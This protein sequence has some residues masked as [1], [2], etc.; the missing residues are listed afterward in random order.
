VSSGQAVIAT[1]AEAARFYAW[2]NLVYLPV[3][4]APPARWALVWRTAT[5]TPV[6]RAFARTIREP[7]HEEA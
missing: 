6:I 3:R 5:E 4:D 2:P 7:T 1:V